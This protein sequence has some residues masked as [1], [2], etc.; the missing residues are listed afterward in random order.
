MERL[1]DLLK[2]NFSPRILSEEEIEIILAG[3]RK[4]I[5][6]HLLT[7]LNRLADAHYKC[8]DSINSHQDREEE[9]VANLERLGGFKSIEER[10]VFVNSLIERNQR[11]A[12]MMNKV[13]QSS[14][15]WALLAFFGFLVASTWNELVHA[16]KIKLGAS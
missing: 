12:D 14:L 3:E 2:Q 16:I 8:V 1:S 13:A 10:A 6:R 7:S 5:D 15:T 11:R 4:A 9:V